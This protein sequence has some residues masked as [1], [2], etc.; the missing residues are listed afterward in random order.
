[1]P[2]LLRTDGELATSLEMLVDADGVVDF[3]LRQ[4]LLSEAWLSTS[5]PPSVQ[6]LVARVLTREAIIL[7]RASVNSSS[8]L[9]NFHISGVPLSSFA[10]S[11][12]STCSSFSD[13]IGS[14]L[15]KNMDS[16]SNGMMR[17]KRG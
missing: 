12:D 9:V 13:S 15:S 17:R 2:D 10:S 6:S 11:M 14:L 4:P 7:L 3:G 16:G 8:P 5:C 1:M